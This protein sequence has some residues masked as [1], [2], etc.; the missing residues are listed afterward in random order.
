MRFE[1][2]EHKLCCQSAWKEL[3]Y[4]LWLDGLM[5]TLEYVKIYF[6][7]LHLMT[8]LR[9]KEGAHYVYNNFRVVRK[10]LQWRKLS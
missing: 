9:I 1:K 2:L 5:F 10:T 3:D 6:S 7:S 8:V 4:Q